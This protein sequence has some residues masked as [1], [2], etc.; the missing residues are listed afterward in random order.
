[1]NLILVDRAAQF[2]TVTMNRPEARNALGRALVADFRST[3]SDL[4]ADPTVRALIVAG[5]RES[6]AFCAGATWSS[7]RR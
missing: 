1:M 3:L 2:A 5:T 6:N 7:G 4:A